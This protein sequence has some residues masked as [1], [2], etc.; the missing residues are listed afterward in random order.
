MKKVF[1]EFFNNH[2]ILG[3]I[4]IL[5]L[6]IGGPLIM[7]FKWLYNVSKKATAHPYISVAFADV[8]KPEG[9]GKKTG[10]FKCSIKMKLLAIFCTLF[11][12][13]ILVRRLLDQTPDSHEKSLL[14]FILL[15][16][17]SVIALF[18]FFRIKLTIYENGMEYHSGYTKRVIYFSEINTLIP[19]YRST[20]IINWSMTSYEAT[21]KI[22]LKNGKNFCLN[23]KVLVGLEKLSTYLNFGENPYIDDFRFTYHPK[24]N[25]AVWK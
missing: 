20:Y 3:V 22:E 24:H 12:A 7:T 14:I 1:N 25:P 17:A 10:M 2:E 8:L 15:E 23:H 16:L 18:V 11:F 5:G 13:F 4:M 6:L 9:L 19:V 21:Y